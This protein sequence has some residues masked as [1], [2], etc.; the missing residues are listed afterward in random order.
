[1]KTLVLFAFATLIS[2]SLFAEQCAK[3][4]QVVVKGLVSTSSMNAQAVQRIYVKGDSQTDKAYIEDILKS[5]NQIQSLNDTVVLVKSRSKSGQCV[6]RGSQSRL[7]ITSNVPYGQKPSANLYI[8]RVNYK[9]SSPTSATG[10]QATLKTELSSFSESRI[11]QTGKT[12]RLTIEMLV[13]IPLGDY[14]TDGYDV[15][16]DIG[17]AKS[18]DFKILN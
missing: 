15:T 2:Q 9:G 7:V 12:S 5:V 1:M 13:Q 18:V 3:S 10:Y 11:V 16:A 14:G 17:Y 4:I 6:Y 8:G